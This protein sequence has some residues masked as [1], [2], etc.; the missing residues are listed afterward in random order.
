MS[1]PQAPLHMHILSCLRLGRVCIM[2]RPDAS[3]LNNKKKSHEETSE[4]SITRC[5][6]PIPPNLR[7]LIIECNPFPQTNP[8][9]H[10]I[11]L[12]LA[13]THSLSKDTYKSG[14]DMFLVTAP[15]LYVSN[16]PH[17]VVNFC[18]PTL[19]EARP[20]SVETKTVADMFAVESGM[21]WAPN[22]HIAFAPSLYSTCRSRNGAK[23]D[24]TPS[25]DLPASVHA[26]LCPLA[27]S[28][29]TSKIRVCRLLSLRGVI[30]QGQGHGFQVLPVSTHSESPAAD[31]R[32]GQA[33]SIWSCLHSS[34]STAKG[35]R[36]APS[37][38]ILTHAKSKSKCS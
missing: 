37:S 4:G 5:P 23:Q 22:S 10:T 15:L 7:Y 32:C 34:R 3:L 29:R 12:F 13:H 35:R 38:I 8:L 6:L 17:N 30:L 14:I 28:A 21:A 36:T 20:S 16:V 2:E 1:A 25:C 26:R 19:C 24:C 33:L 31:A 27:P 9:P 18:K 11:D